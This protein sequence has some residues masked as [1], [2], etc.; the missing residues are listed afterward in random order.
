MIT[1]IRLKNL[2]TVNRNAVYVDYVNSKEKKDL[3]TVKLY[4]SYETIVGIITA[5]WKT[6]CRVNDWSTTTGKL[7]NDIEPD[8]KARIT[9]EEFIKIVAK[10]FVEINK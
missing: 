3:K 2:G 7:L 5:D 1:D 4:F 6:Y 8:H 10:V 9:G